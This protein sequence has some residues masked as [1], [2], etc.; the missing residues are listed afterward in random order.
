MLNEPEDDKSIFMVHPQKW[1][2][3]TFE[4]NMAQP[5]VATINEILP[6]NAVEDKT[7]SLTDHAPLVGANDNLQ[8]AQRTFT[9]FGPMIRYLE[10]GDLSTESRKGGSMLAQAQY[11]VMISGTLFYL[12]HH[13]SKDIPKADRLICKLAAPEYY[14]LQVIECYHDFGHQGFERCNHAIILKYYWPAMSSDVYQHVQSCQYC[15][16]AKHNFQ[17]PKHSLKP[18]SNNRNIFTRHIGRPRHT[19][20]KQEYIYSSGS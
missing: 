15:Q 14:T 12:Y 3:A 7:D 6:V 13:A 1:V 10:T 8:L 4:D 16:R 5:P 2:K 11:F 17:C 19:H 18:T 20:S 9:D